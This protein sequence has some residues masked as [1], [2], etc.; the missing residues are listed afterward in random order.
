MGLLCKSKQI[1]PKTSLSPHTHTHTKKPHS[2]GVKICVTLFIL[3]FNLQE[4]CTVNEHIPNMA[5]EQL[6]VDSESRK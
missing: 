3:L 2:N 1:T 6:T 4:E 5:V